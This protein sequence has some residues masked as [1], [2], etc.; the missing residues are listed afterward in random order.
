MQILFDFLPI[1]LF[2]ISYKLFNIYLATAIMMIASLIQVLFLRLKKQRF[3]SLSLIILAMVLL[4][5]GATLL[6]HNEIF[7]KWK[8]TVVYWILA[9]VFLGSQLL[10]KPFIE[11][12]MAERLSLPPH[13][14]RHLNLGWGIFFLAIG[15]INLYVAYNFKTTIWVNFKLFGVFSLM[16]A[17]A[18]YQASYLA[19]YL[20]QDTRSD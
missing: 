14:W 9:L 12:L 16:L 6:L 15:S 5:G 17:F 1:V 2:F 20:G 18:I 4:L 3:E 7:I 11:H 10:N 19:R 13:A 8:P